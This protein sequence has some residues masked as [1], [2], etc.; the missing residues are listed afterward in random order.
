MLLALVFLLTSCS[1]NQSSDITA[2]IA[3]GVIMPPGSISEAGMVRE[4]EHTLWEV[5]R[6]NI[7]RYTT[8]AINARFTI[9]QDL[10]FPQA[11]GVFYH[12]F[13]TETG[14]RVQA[15]DIIAMQVLPENEREALELERIR[16]AFQIE[17]FESRAAEEQTQRRREISQARTD[18]AN[19]GGEVTRLELARL[20]LMYD[21]F[22]YE[23]QQRRQDY[24]ERLENMYLPHAYIYA[25]FDGVVTN[26]THPSY[27][28]NVVAGLRY[29]LL[30]DEASFEFTV[31]ALT[32]I[33]R[34]G[35]VFTVEHDMFSFEGRVVTDPLVYGQDGHQRFSIMPVDHEAFMETITALNLTLYDITRMSFSA[36]LVETLAHDVLIVYTHAIRREDRNFY[37]LIYQDGRYL[38][39]YVIR[40]LEHL[41]DVEILSGVEE[42]QM[43]VIP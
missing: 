26:I 20:Q 42:G 31:S 13:I 16:M 2:L 21:R 35:N 5:Q 24:N 38:K 7:Q 17:Q 22:L 14:T 37:V 25:P 27:G 40:G 43:V 10:Y 15:G 1:P 33:V 29:F 9:T 28:S 6:G 34:Y 30:S 36:N 23:T 4:A 8:I 39:R 19:Y 11:G 12:P 32:D 3:E 41:R 18:H